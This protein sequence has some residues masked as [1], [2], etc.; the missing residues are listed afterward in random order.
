MKINT[1]VFFGGRSVEH[2]V[3]VITGVQAMMSL[4][5]EKYNVI[6]V[7]IAKDGVAAKT[8][9]TL[10]I[11]DEEVYEVTGGISS[12]DRVIATWHP[13]LADGAAVAVQ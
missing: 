2:E 10:G 5:R 4:D 7:Y 1:A 9:V 13:D 11:T 8:F 12:A 6:P 3:S